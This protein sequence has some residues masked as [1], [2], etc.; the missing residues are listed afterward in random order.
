MPVSRWRQVVDRLA[1][2]KILS[3]S[4]DVSSSGNDRQPLDQ[5]HPVHDRDVVRELL[6]DQIGGADGHNNNVRERNGASRCC[7]QEA[8]GAPRFVSAVSDVGLSVSVDVSPRIQI[9]ASG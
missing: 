4:C 1:A 8:C 3:V 5:P 6:D 9:L 7:G 2:N